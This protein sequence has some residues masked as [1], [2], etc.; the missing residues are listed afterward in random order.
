ME[1]I[2]IICGTIFNANG[3]DLACSLECR[4]INEKNKRKIYNKNY[5]R[6]KTKKSISDKKYIEKVKNT[7]HYKEKLKEI[8]VRYRKTEKYKE[9]Q[10]RYKDEHQEQIRKV[11]KIYNKKHT[12]MLSDYYVLRALNLKKQEAPIKLIEAKR[13]QLKLHRL[14]KEKT[15]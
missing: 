10:K 3:R 13:E 2:C 12:K 8:R 15:S 7:E 14:I 6:D 1:R 4:N 5:K 11:A 9:Y